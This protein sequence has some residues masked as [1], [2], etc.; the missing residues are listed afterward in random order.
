MNGAESGTLGADF[1]I[2]DADA[3]PE[4][5]E[6]LSDEV[7]PDEISPS[8]PPPGET[9]RESLL[10]QGRALLATGQSQQA[11]AV[12]MQALEIAP[13]DAL[14]R[15]E[16]THALRAA[17]L[18]R[19]AET[20]E[21]L[22]LRSADA[23]AEAWEK[24]AEQMLE[25]GLHAATCAALRRAVARKP[26]AMAL[27]LRLADLERESDPGAAVS[28][29][30]RLLLQAPTLAPAH[31]GLGAALLTLGRR[32][33]ARSHLEYALG[34]DPDNA[35][36]RV[37]R[38]RLRLSEG[39]FAAAW[40]D[41][42]WR[43]ELAGRSRPEGPG[44]PWDG[45]A[46]LHQ[47]TI[48]VWS[49]PGLG[50][51]LHLLRYVPAL[52]ALGGRIILGVPEVLLTLAETLPGVVAVLPPGADLPDGMADGMAVEFNV[53]LAELPQLF[54][55]S[56]TSIPLAPYL[57]PPPA[58]RRPLEVSSTALLKVGL[59]WQGTTTRLSFL[60]T[61][62]LLGIGGVAVFA[63][64]EADEDL[65]QQGHPALI[66]D[67]SPTVGDMADLA[68][69]IAEMDLVIAPDGPVAHL[70]GALG[71]PVWVMT[72][73]LP[74]W[75]WAVVGEQPAWYASARIFP[76]TGAG[77]EGVV[78]EMAEALNQK[79]AI[80]RLRREKAG[81]PL[82]MMAPQDGNA[83]TWTF[84]AGWLQAGD[85][86]VEVGAGALPYALEAAAHPVGAIH[87]LAID[88]DPVMMRRLGES[89]VSW[90]VENAIEAITAIV[91]ADDMIPPEPP[92]LAHTVFFLPADAV[93]TPPPVVTLESLLGA[94]PALAGRRL[95]LH[96]GPDAAGEEVLTG[97]STLPAM[98]VF[99]HRNGRLVAAGLDSAGH[100]LFRLPKEGPAGPLV[101]FDGREGPV[102]A[103]APEIVDQALKGNGM[104][105]TLAIR[106]P[107]VDKT[108][109][110]A[111]RLTQEG[112]EALGAEQFDQ[113]EVL[114][115]Y[116]LTLDSANA[117][118]N[119]GLGTLLHR[120]GREH[121]AAL[122]W[123]RSGYVGA[124]PWLGTPLPPAAED[125]SDAMPWEGGSLAERSLLVRAP[126]NVKE[127][128]LLT[129]FLLPLMDLGAQLFVE[130]PWETLRLLE[131]I[132]GIE[133]VLPHGDPL[134]ETD[135]VV[136]LDAVP[137]LLPAKAR[138]AAVLPAPLAARLLAPAERG[139][140]RVGVAWGET[141]PCVAFLAFAA[142]PSLALFNLQRG[143]RA[144]ELEAMGEG[145]FLQNTI[146]ES[147]D[148][149][150]LAEI[151]GQLDLV[152]AP[153]GV[154]ARLAMA[155]G[156]NTWVLGE[157]PQG[158]PLSRAFLVGADGEWG[159]T[160]AG[161]VEALR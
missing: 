24:K 80:E 50:S 105:E 104:A 10:R 107:S 4:N 142:L 15:W 34:R 73:A 115:T 17:G 21:R 121:A 99:E 38:A 135:F 43:W 18:V 45:S 39:H 9:K 112:L 69:R 35:L 44:E 22:V 153:D 113:A 30:H 25:Q 28:C 70:A 125:D 66:A 90:G 81:R 76:Q 52:S 74:D 91:G 57:S 49:E 78:A 143:A 145:F 139:G 59:A 137:D 148:L 114:L 36:A 152:I 16:M 58:R 102:L 110:E 40:S 122:C 13:E 83:S 117:D 154:E 124:P 108:A 5:A 144:E 63:L 123:Q 8:S 93:S 96:L 132:P 88:S 23:P 133:H 60:Q 68:A 119:G 51:I 101:R 98:A 111:A 155:L 26:E 161:M 128:V 109:A 79:A 3:I 47:R 55:S 37:T 94:R 87:V 140:L 89:A 48:L 136:A 27:R 64:Q 41:W 33:E 67:L 103:L 86:L 11:L 116:A 131:S 7:I 118:A 159:R 126:K 157:M 20:L 156:K 120:K 100:K 56:L 127:T 53:S 2:V 14:V 72:A 158:T 97:L 19:Q 141:V 82:Q 32:E 85:L 150:G 84:L 146:Q 129:R 151:I 6:S 42:G 92:P 95:V 160:F 54:A 147:D 130:G 138:I 77:W 12:L 1:S 75:R 71:I 134:P 31:A 46:D 61:L 106:R 149:V 65:H 29:Y 62:P